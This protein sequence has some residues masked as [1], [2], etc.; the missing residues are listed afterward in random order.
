MI[1]NTYPLSSESSVRL[2]ALP[3]SLPYGDREKD[4][5]AP[6]GFVEVK[7]PVRLEGLPSDYKLRNPNVSVTVD[8]PG[9]HFVSPWQTANVGY[10]VLSFLLPRMVFQRAAER[11]AHL[12]LEFL[13]EKLRPGAKQVV[14]ATSSFSVPDD[15]RCIFNY[16]IPS[17]RYAFRMLTPTRVE[18]SDEHNACGPSHF[19]KPLYAS[20]HVIP[21]GG[22]IDPIIHQDLRFDRKICPGTQLT[23]FQYVPAG[24][25]R[26]ELDLPSIELAQYKAH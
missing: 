10:D 3:G 11:D 7:L 12:H 22:R 9:V 14:T 21:D 20:L 15:G 26:L 23:F 16:G 1:R 25:F 6:K 8:A 24:K 18:A 5:Q 13:A 17:C 2:V 4:M 19:D